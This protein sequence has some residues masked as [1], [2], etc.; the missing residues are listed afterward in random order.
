M[1][2]KKKVERILHSRK[3]KLLNVSNDAD[4]SITPRAGLGAS[5]IGPA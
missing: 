3:G 1:K 2:S 4:M 5:G